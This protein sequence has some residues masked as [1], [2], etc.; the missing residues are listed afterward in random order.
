MWVV[1]PDACV[2]GPYSSSVRFLRGA[3]TTTITAEAPGSSVSASDTAS[4]GHLHGY[5]RV[6]TRPQEVALQL[7]ALDAAGCARNPRGSPSRTS[8]WAPPLSR[9]HMKAGPVHDPCRGAG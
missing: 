5:A 1:S 4:G 8:T 9:E 2:T 3:A 7:D 6:S